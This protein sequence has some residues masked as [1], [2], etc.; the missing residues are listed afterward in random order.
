MN[1]RK[2]N[3]ASAGYGDAVQNIEDQ[4]QLHRT[5]QRRP[6]RPATGLVALGFREG[7]ARG[8]VDVL[9]ELWSDL[10]DTARLRAAELAARYQEAA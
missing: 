10:D 2:D 4:V 7:F 8:A 3:G 5:H 9:R 6:H 1:R